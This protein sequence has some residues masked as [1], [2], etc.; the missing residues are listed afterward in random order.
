MFI[1]VW[2]LISFTKIRLERVFSF[3]GKKIGK[4][5]GRLFLRL[6][7]VSYELALKDIKSIHFVE[8]ERQASLRR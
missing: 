3:E 6:V 8:L 1:L 7:K 2:G 4:R 5:Y